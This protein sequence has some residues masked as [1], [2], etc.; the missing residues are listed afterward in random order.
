VHIEGHSSQYIRTGDSGQTITFHFCPAC[1]TTLCW[2]L[3][4]Y[5]DMVVVAVGAFADPRFLPP[6]FSVYEYSRHPWV[7]IQ[8]PVQREN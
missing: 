2:D 3:A 1:G 8:E 4:D 5:P 6:Q 7:A